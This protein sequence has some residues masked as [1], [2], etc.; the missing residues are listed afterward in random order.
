MFVFLFKER[1]NYFRYIYGEDNILLFHFFLLVS[2]LVLAVDDR[3]TAVRISKGTRRNRLSNEQRLARKKI[4]DCKQK[5][6]LF[7]GTFSSQF[8]TFD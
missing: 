8:Y 2:L 1:G 3:L 6:L 7:T 4:F 5:L